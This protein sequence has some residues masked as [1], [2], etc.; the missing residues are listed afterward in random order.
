MKEVAKSEVLGVATLV[1]YQDGAVVSRTLTKKDTG[2]MSVFA[3]DK[4]EGLSEHTTPFDATVQVLDGSVDI[5]ISGEVYRVSAGEMI[6]M[7]ANEPHGLKAPE[8]FKM[9]LTMIRS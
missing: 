6:I 4:G 5:T 7:P 3:F 9:I 1:D 2:T 8:R